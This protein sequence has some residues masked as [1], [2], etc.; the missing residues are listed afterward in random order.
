MSR[1]NKNNPVLEGLKIDAVAAEGRAIAHTDDGQVVFV[2]FA[3]PGDIVD[4]Q[5]T[6][7]KK[8]YLE[9][10]IVALKEASEHRQ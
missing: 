5:V 9:G 8:K 2:E 4:I 7:K 6:K 1:K 10:R 3:V